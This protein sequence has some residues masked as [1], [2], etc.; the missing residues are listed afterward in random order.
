MTLARFAW[1][2]PTVN[3]LHAMRGIFCSHHQ[4]YALTLVLRL[5]IGKIPRTT[6]AQLVIFI[7]RF[8]LVRAMLN[9]LHAIQG[10]LSTHQQIC[11]LTLVQLDIGRTP[12]ITY[13]HP[14]ILPAWFVW[15]G[16]ILNALLAKQGIL[17]NRHRQY[18]LILV[19]L[20]IGKI[21][22]AAFARLA[23]LLVRFALERAIINAQPAIL[24]ILSTR[25]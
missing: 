25:R 20:D 6:V 10:I 7:V 11:A 14:A 1:M 4:Q 13:A 8:A 3:V 2:K 18:A 21:Q 15:M 9:A 17:S 22:R 5:D 12:R 16:P 19:Q 23:M 24:D